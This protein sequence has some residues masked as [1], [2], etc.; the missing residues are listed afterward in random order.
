MKNA[1]I[2][3]ALFT[4]CFSSQA[5]ITVTGQFSRKQQDIN[6][7]GMLVLGGWAA[8]NL[9]YSGISI[10]GAN[11]S[12]R[13]F[14]QMNLLWA[15]INGALATAGYLGSRKTDSSS[16]VLLRRQRNLEKV[17]LLNAGLDLAYIAGGF[18]LKERANRNN[19][20]S[21]RNRG[22]GNSIILQGAGLLLFDGVMYVLHLKNGRQIFQHAD[23][24]SIGI[25]GAGIGCIV[26]L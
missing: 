21:D 8:G 24:I 9:L 13:Y 19:K 17:F 20:N 11:G 10:G 22:F 18:Y 5:Q 15:G 16:T 1:I 12:N 3:S 4:L 7:K 2:I 14:H 6:R 26:K 25:T 23:K